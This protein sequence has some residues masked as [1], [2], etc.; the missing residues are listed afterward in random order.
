MLLFVIVDSQ[1]AIVKEN[2]TLHAMSRITLQCSD[3]RR[4]EQELL[5]QELDAACS[6][7]EL[8]NKKSAKLK[9]RKKELKKRTKKDTRLI[10]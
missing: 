1:E 7:L 2:L 4:E 10:E 5:E 3:G 6:A 9:T 8:A